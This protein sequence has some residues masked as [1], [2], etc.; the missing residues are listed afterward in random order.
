MTIHDLIPN[1]NHNITF[2]ETLVSFA[3]Q[4][5]KTTTTKSSYLL[6]KRAY[7]ALH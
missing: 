7:I 2:F 1:S 5:I 4:A 3:S 6:L